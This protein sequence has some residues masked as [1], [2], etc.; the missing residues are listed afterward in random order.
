ML[1]KVFRKASSATPSAPDPPP[2]SGRLTR[3]SERA[4]QLHTAPTS[5]SGGS[6]NDDRPS[7]LGAGAGTGATLAGYAPDDS[8]SSV[9]CTQSSTSAQ[10]YKY[11][12]LSQQQQNEGQQPAHTRTHSAANNGT[13]SPPTTSRVRSYRKPT[14]ATPQGRADDD[15]SRLP[16]I[17]SLSLGHGASDG[18][19][20]Q[21]DV[22]DGR[23][24]DPASTLYRAASNNQ[25]KIMQQQQA[26]NGS[27]ATPHHPQKST[28]QK[29]K[30]DA[31]GLL[32]GAGTAAVLN[33]NVFGATNGDGHTMGDRS[34][35]AN[36]H[37]NGAGYLDARATIPNG[38]EKHHKGSAISL[39]SGISSIDG[40]GS[41]SGK[42]KPVPTYEDEE[43][44][45]EGEQYKQQAV[46][47]D[48]G[49]Q[50]KQPAAAAASVQVVVQR[51]QQQQQASNRANGIGNGIAS[52]SAEQRTQ[53]AT[54][55]IQV[56]PQQ[57]HYLVKALVALQMAN[58]ARDI[59]KVGALTFYGHPFSAER[60]KL[61]RIKKDL[62]NEYTSGGGFEEVADEAYG[63][64][65]DEDVIRRAE[66]VQEP[67]ILRHLFHANLLPFPGLDTAP[68][69]YWQARIQ[70]FFDE[71]AARNFSTSM[72]RGELSK[73]RFFA[74]AGIRYLSVFFARG[75]GIRGEGETRGPGVGEPGSEKWGK[76][77]QWGKGTVKRG[78]DRPVRIDAPLMRQIDDLFHA[79]SEEGHQWRLA[80]KEAARIRTDWQAFKEHVIEHEDGIE[81]VHRHLDINNIKNLPT[82]YRNAEEWARNHA[83]YIFHTLFVS[84]PGADGTFKVLKGIVGLFPF[85]ATRQI[86]KYANAQVMIQGI[87]SLLLAR[88]A[89]SKS[90]MQ[91]VF[92]FVIG[93]EISSIEKEYITPL[94]NAITDDELAKLVE[95]YVKRGS[96]PEKRAIR[97]KTLKS[98]NDVL[99][100]ILL[101]GNHNRP[102]QQTQERIMHMQRCFGLSTLRSRLDDAYPDGTPPAQE[103]KA[104]VAGFGLGSS[105]TDAEAARQF[106]LL[107]LLLR[108]CLKK[109]D[110]EQASAMATGSLIP[111]IIKDSLE[112]VFYSIIKEIASTADLS[113][114]LG[115]LQAFLEDLIK[116][117]LNT[118]NSLQEWIA[119]C[120][121]HENSLYYFFHE[122][123]SIAEPFIDWLQLG[124]DYMA[125]S[126]SDPAHPADRS[127]KNIEVNVEKMLGDNR[128]TD[129]DVRRILREVD[130]LT[131]YTLWNKVWYELELRK[132]FLLARPDAAPVSGLGE[133]D[134]PS[135]TFKKDIEDI[136]SLLSD[137]MTKKGVKI[138]DGLCRSEARGT[139]AAEFPWIWFDEVD[140]CGQHLMA[141]EA[142]ADL[143]YEPRGMSY[144]PP[145]LLHTRK[146]LPIFREILLSE[147]PDRMRKTPLP[148]GNARRASK[149]STSNKSDKGGADTRSVV[150]KK[151]AKSFKIPF[152]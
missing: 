85:W 64:D 48:A 124:A 147:M 108:E 10:R 43:G 89:G 65:A 126:T 27:A 93:R 104:P 140:P 37:A 18:D 74:L 50:A 49:Y 3:Y 61:K 21:E 12:Y 1:A 69:K 105:T 149:F 67:V 81:D 16:P 132:N 79:D 34:A 7:T 103:R 118:D 51:A 139:E 91:R 87:L 58:E 88:P 107:K 80:G 6:R 90:L 36:N 122:C 55:K 68:L 144:P 127:R 45:E 78:L 120:A 40:S 92:S 97:A 72:E 151:S 125:L 137:L 136:D 86:L 71:M 112:N 22:F 73:R 19:T 11:S 101:E 106:A 84:S 28:L 15:T 138:N 44:K 59:E 145:N 116:V 46:E 141:E 130:N 119:L 146:V 109:R 35:N 110:R 134:L 54:L 4:R 143:R 30:D 2:P 26:H 113:A 131:Q 39:V 111:T 77:K 31:G 94:R 62:E 129:D 38:G 17:P 98:G 32:T 14:T 25:L 63:E 100:T 70:V 95:E 56:T 76:G 142:V 47:R 150:S 57:R 23:N 66:G 123:A 148:P 102:Q 128:L 96:R 117:K 8:N 75:V 52:V 99:T 13:S 121:R 133:K 42:R 60:P 115:D 135:P 9:T 82:H 152:L 20:P 83:A 24:K 33:N 29:G 41:G 5:T 114:R 53:K